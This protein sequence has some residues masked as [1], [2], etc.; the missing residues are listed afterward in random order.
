MM[1][2]DAVIAAL[3][4]VT[5]SYCWRLNRRITSFRN[6]KSELEH[7]IRSFDASI[8][9]A[10]ESIA[11]LKDNSSDKNIKLIRDMEKVRFLANDLA[12]LVEKGEKLADSLESTIRQ[13]APRAEAASSAPTT[14]IPA[15]PA[16]PARPQ[17]QPSKPAPSSYM[18]PEAPRPPQPQ[19]AQ[20]RIAEVQHMIDTLARSYVTDQPPKAAASAAPPSLPPRGA[21]P[22]RPAAALI[23]HT[24]TP[25]ERAQAIEKVLN[26]MA[27]NNA[28]NSATM[29][30][31]PPRKITEKT[32]APQRPIAAIAA[33]AKKN[34][35]FDTL[36]V[37]TPNE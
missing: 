31:V 18:P 17:S 6:A 13:N 30:S 28:R 33:A 23:N 1:L 25:E 32:A 2:L 16:R 12:Y 3:L 21:A 36:R 7:M 22:T 37:I 9:Q 8:R 15:R 14:S 27:S 29:P 5:A 11:V 24:A 35:F 26:H 34:P 20:P 10:Y 19:H 4:A